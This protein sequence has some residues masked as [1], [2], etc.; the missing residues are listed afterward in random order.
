MRRLWTWIA[1]LLA[2]YVT[3]ELVL[4]VWR[5]L[6]GLAVAVAVVYVAGVVRGH[7]RAHW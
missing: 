1:V 4:S 3:A 5:V 7:R 2:L 6:L